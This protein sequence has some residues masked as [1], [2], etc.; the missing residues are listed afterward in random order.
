M[1]LPHAESFELVPTLMTKNSTK[2]TLSVCLPTYDRYETLEPVVARLLNQHYQNIDIVISDN[3]QHKQPPVSLLRMFEA[4]CRIRYVRQPKNIG[5]IA[6]HSFVRRAAMGEYV[7]MLHDDDEIPLDYLGRM[8]ELL[9]SDPSICLCGPSCERFYEGKFWYL[10]EQYNSV[11]RTQEARLFDIIERAFARPWDFEHLFY[12][13]YRRDAIPS[14]FE[15]GPW[16]SIITFFY[17]CSISGGIAVSPDVVMRKNNTAADM[18][19]YAKAEYVTRSPILRAV[20]RSRRLESRLTTLQRFVYFTLASE[21]LSFRMKLSLI[22]RIFSEFR[23]NKQEAGPPPL[24][25]GSA[26]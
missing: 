12:G 10:Y 17:L 26:D 16:R 4:D 13:V 7:C 2:P 11:G 1:G 14:G 22:R 8:V 5:M 20:C 18:E 24:P 21:K 25:R 6:N 19:K 3:T 9:N 15:F 23:K